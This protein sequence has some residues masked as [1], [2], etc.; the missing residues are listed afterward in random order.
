VRVRYYTEKND[1]VK[2]T[3]LESFALVPKLSIFDSQWNPLLS[4]TSHM[5]NGHNNVSH[6]DTLLTDTRVTRT[7]LGHDLEIY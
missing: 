1:Q 5:D 2:L 7:H 4:A 6:G 3:Y